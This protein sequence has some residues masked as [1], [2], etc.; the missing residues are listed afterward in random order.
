MSTIHDQMTLLAISTLQYSQG[1]DCKYT[2][3]GGD[4]RDITGAVNYGTIDPLSPLPAG[5]SDQWTLTVKNS[6]TEGIARSEL[7]VGKDMVKVP[8][9]KGGSLVERRIAKLI[10]ETHGY[11]VLDIR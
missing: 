3:N 6:E 11:L 2:P 5:H 8:K 4:E 7:D 9:T 1:V 10:T